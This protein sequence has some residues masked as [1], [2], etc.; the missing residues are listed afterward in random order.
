MSTSAGLGR[1]VFRVDRPFAFSIS[2][3]RTGAILFLGAVADPRG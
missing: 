3:Q 1:T 2:D